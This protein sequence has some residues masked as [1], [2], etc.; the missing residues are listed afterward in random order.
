MWAGFVAFA[1]GALLGPFRPSA[2]PPPKREASYNDDIN[3]PLYES[4]LRSC[5]GAQRKGIR[6][7]HPDASNVHEH[8]VCA[9]L[10]PFFM[11]QSTPL[12]PS[13]FRAV[14]FLAGSCSLA[15]SAFWQEQIGALE[16]LVGDQEGVAAKWDA[17]RPAVLR[18]LEPMNVLLLDFLMRRFNIGGPKWI[19]QLIYGFPIT[20]TLSHDSTYP[21]NEKAPHPH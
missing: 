5:A 2:F 8:V 20:G 6:D 13:T 10:G 11:A 4:S 7:E 18:P 3:F 19:G 14:D 15:V 21:R 16:R 17:F 12:P 9:L 1:D